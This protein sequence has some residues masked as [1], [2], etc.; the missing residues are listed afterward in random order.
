[1]DNFTGPYWSDGKLQES[2]EFGA[3]TPLNDLDIASRLHDSAY[4]HYEAGTQQRR[5]ADYLY[6]EEVQNLGG[7]GQFAG[8]A[9]L[10]GNQVTNA[11]GELA[12]DA[13]TGFKFG[14]LLGG[15]VGLIYGGVKNE[16]NLIDWMDNKNKYLEEVRS[17]YD[18]D[19]YKDKEGYRK[20]HATLELVQGV[21]NPFVNPVSYDDL[22][23]LA[24]TKWVDTGPAVSSYGA[25]RGRRR[26]YRRT[27]LYQYV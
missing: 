9:V 22:L 5:A 25:A 16:L 13:S 2:V 7:L 18:T 12:S 15:L 8:T 17:Y 14:G 1:M 26:R 21:D 20:R 27:K 24:P 19:P 11:L 4:A 23:E 6:Y 10:Y 3:T